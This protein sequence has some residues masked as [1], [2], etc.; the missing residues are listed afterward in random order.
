[1]AYFA[2]ALVV[3][4]LPSVAGISHGALVATLAFSP[5]DLLAGKIWLLPLSGIVVDGAT[6][7]QLAVLAEAA[8]VLVAM[9][10]ARTFWRAALLAHVGSTLIAYAVLGILNVA[11][12][13]ATGDL[14]RDPDYGVSCIWAGSLGALAVVA[15]RRCT[16]RSAKV[17]VVAAISAPLFVV[18]STGIV[19]AAGT[20]DLAAVEHVLAFLLGALA[21]RAAVTKGRTVAR[22]PLPGRRRADRRAERLL[23][24]G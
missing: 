18:D 15:A 2:A 12:P 4:L 20:L 14:L 7:V 9:A 8:V 16:R 22:A 3:G 24:S 5:S 1:M 11:D 10:G 17:A 13:S 23:T 19:T 21:G 6:W